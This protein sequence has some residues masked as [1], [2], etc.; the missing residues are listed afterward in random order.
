MS[1]YHTKFGTIQKKKKPFLKYFIW[2]IIVLLIAASAAAYLLFQIVYKPNVWTPDGKN[3]SVYIP[4]KSNFDDVKQLLFEKG[5]IV[6]RNNFIWWAE[7]KN[8]PELIKPG[9]YVIKNNISNDDL[10]G[11]LRSGN[12]AP[13]S[14]IFNNIRDVYQLAGVV[15]TQIEADSISIVNE[16]TS[17]QTLLSVDLTI[18]TISTIFIPNTY[19]FYWNTNAAGFVQRMHEEYLS[20]WNADRINKAKDIDLTISEVVTLASIVEKESNKSSEK[21]MIAGVYINRLKHNWRLQADPTVIYALNDYDIKRVLRVHTDFDSPYNTYMYAGLPPG[22][23]CIPSISSIDAV[24]NNTN[25]GYFYF[26]AKDDM[27]GFHV[28]ARSNAQH[29]RNARKYQKALNNMKI[30]K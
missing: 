5:L 11:L 17:A 26:C 22:P 6:H 7:R 4:T 10:I 12:Q 9:H 2:F 24:L 8:Y 19:E 15:S 3:I 30:Y 28:F 25:D 13:V 29:N 23:I 20:F 27:S 21:P 14:V 16:I 18:E 1:Y